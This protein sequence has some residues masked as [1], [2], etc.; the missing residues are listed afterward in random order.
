MKWLCTLVS[1]PSDTYIL[2][3][4]AGSGTTAIACELLGLKWVA[5]DKYE[6]NCMDAYN[7]MKNLCPDSEMKL[8]TDVK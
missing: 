8:V 5:I 4:F 1:S 3:P 6:N 7:R 2:D